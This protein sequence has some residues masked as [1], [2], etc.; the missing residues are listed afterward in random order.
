MLVTLPEETPVN[1]V[2][3]TAFKLEDKVGVHLTP[4]VVNALYRELDLDIDPIEAAAAAGVRLTDA[5]VASLRRA[6]AF[7]THRQRLQ[8]AQTRRL[9]EALP[10]GQLHL[11]FL[12]T[13]ELGADE[14]EELAEALEGELATLPDPFP[15]PASPASPADAGAGSP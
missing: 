12:F 2:V 4:I 8:A 7:R 6:A 15:S 11:P 14:V 13:T 3:E 1:E 9:A 5:E 10:L